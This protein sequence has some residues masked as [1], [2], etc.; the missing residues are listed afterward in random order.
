MGTKPVEPTPLKSWDEFI[1][2]PVSCAWENIGVATGMEIHGF[3]V[4]M[5]LTC[6]PNPFS[7]MATIKYLLPENGR[8]NME[9][10]GILGNRIKLLSNQFQTVGEYVL[11]LDGGMLT[12]GI[13]QITLRLTNLNGGEWTKTIRMIKQ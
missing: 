8:V 13:Y 12:A 5:T 11:D 3:A 6:Y 4:E 2:N 7:E 1:F 10:T 9:V